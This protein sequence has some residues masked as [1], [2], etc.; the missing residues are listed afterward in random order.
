MAGRLLR[1]AGVLP[2]YAMTAFEGLAPR[3]LGGPGSVR[4]VQAVVCSERGVLLCVRREL[5][6]WE[7]PGGE[8]EPG[9]ADE[10][11]L[12][13]E[14]REETGL[15]VAIERT[16]G[17]YL[18]TGFRAHRARVFV[19]HV[20]G[21]ALRPSREAPCLAWFDPAQLPATIFPWFR[22]P[23]EDAL[24][25]FPEPVVRREHLGPAAVWAGLRIDLRMRWRDDRDR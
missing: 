6:G 18:R 23:L 8:V 3:A 1:L 7:L 2:A 11:A 21:G 15:E 12:R 22:I 14:V 24:R 13:R 25:E 4:V 5:R 16:V 17:D 9:E 10:D 20:V 19:C